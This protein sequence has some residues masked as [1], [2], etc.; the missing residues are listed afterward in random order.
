MKL[1]FK[2]V[3]KD[4]DPKLLKTPCSKAAVILANQVKK[5]TAPYVPML[6]GSLNERA[7][8]DGNVL[9]YPGPYARYLYAGKVMVNAAT[10]KGPRYIPEVGYRWP[11]G[12]TLKPTERDLNY[13]KDFH[14]KA[15]AQWFEASKKDNMNTWLRVAEKA[16]KNAL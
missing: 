11:L 5:D 10:G 8:V 9:I 13:T 16:V 7:Y 12:A 15:Q 3:Y 2:T 4:I 6:T 14:P 1:H